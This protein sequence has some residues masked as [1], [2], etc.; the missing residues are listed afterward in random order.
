[1]SFRADLHC[2]S[3]C[4]DGSMSPVELVDHAV[5]VG[6]KGL[7]ITDHDAIEAFFLAKDRAE[8]QGLFLLPGVEFSSSLGGISVHILGY[9]FDPWDPMLAAFCKKHQRIREKRN[10][11]ILDLLKKYH[12]VEISKEELLGVSFSGV[13]QSSKSIGRPHIAQ[14]LVNK[15]VAKSIAD[16]F[17]RFIGDNRPCFVRGERF[18]VAE[19]I[20]CIHRAGGKA[21]IAHPHFIKRRRV[22]KEL[23]SF[24]FDGVEAYYA[25]LHPSQEK[26]WVEI[27]RERKWLLTGGSDFHGSVKPFIFL[28]S[29]WVCEKTFFTLYE[30]YQGHYAGA[31]T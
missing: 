5:E 4:S 19:T 24:N 27:G 25:R 28:G 30:H 12:G 18:S 20:D 14:I 21:V 26:K 29:S 31:T 16:A 6:L 8:E 2:H 13:K 22:E 1:M 7:S 9:A 10:Q 15:G 23:L 11:E 3:T 17:N